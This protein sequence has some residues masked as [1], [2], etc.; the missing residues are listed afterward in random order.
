ML[1]RWFVLVVT[2]GLLAA[3][4]PAGA[5]RVRARFPAVVTTG[6][7]VRVPG[8]VSGSLQVRLEQRVRGRWQRRAAGRHFPLRWRA[9]RAA[10]V[11]GGRG[12]AP[13]GRRGAGA[14]GGGGGGPWAAR[15]VLAPPRR[16]GR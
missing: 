7:L 9:P 6:A 11:A 12:V 10:G 3:P 4:P 15:G 2:V 8:R 5:V 13:R 14:P 1:L 16:G